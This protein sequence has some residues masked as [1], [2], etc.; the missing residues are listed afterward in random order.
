MKG[1]SLPVNMVVVI[2]VAVIVLLSLAAFFMSGFV[3]PT[4]KMSD[5]D[6][7]NTGCGVW[8]MRGC[9]IEDVTKIKIAGYDTNGDG[10]DDS[11]AVACQRVFGYSQSEAESTGTDNPCWIKC[12]GWG[13]TG[14]ATTT[15]TGVAPPPSP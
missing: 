5:T 10:V 3:H 13:G 8:R 2:A 11:L 12:C 4:T 6:A 14:G 9:K 7:W 1:I 15:T